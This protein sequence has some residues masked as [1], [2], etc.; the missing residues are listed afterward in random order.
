MF[1]LDRLNA[2]HSSVR[3]RKA[4]CTIFAGMIMGVVAFNIPAASAEDPGP[5]T[6]ALDTVAHPEIVIQGFMFGPKELKIS[7]GTTV[8]WINQ[9]QAPHTVVEKNRLFRSPPLDTDDSFSFKFDQLGTYQYFCSLHPQMVGSII[10]VPSG[11][12]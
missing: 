11:N 12:E 10:V 7:L 3:F 1:K 6:K 2:A 8:K 5:P 9:D 4:H